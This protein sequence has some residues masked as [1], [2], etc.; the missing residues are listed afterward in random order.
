MKMMCIHVKIN[1]PSRVINKKLFP[2]SSAGCEMKSSVVTMFVWPTAWRPIIFSHFFVCFF[3]AFLINH[4]VYIV[5]ATHVLLE[6]FWLLFHR[7]LDIPSHGPEKGISCWNGRWLTGGKINGKSQKVCCDL[8]ST[9][10][11]IFTYTK[12]R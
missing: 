6:L 2:S 1:F 5:H 11:D 10:E 8:L 9:I 7:F 3:F 12:S 4:S